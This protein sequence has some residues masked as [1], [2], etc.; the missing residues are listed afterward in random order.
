MAYAKRYKRKTPVRRYKRN[1]ASVKK[2]ASICRKVV[3]KNIETKHSVF[4]TSDGTEIAHNN[5]ITVTNTLLRTTQG[6]GDN[7]VANVSNR[8]GDS[9]TIKGVAIRMMLELNERYSDIVCRVLII[10][11][12]KNDTPTRASLFYGQSGNKMLDKI[13]NERYTVIAQKF[14]KIK[15]AN[16]ATQGASIATIAGGSA[17]T[18]LAGGAYTTQS[19]ATSIQKMWIPGYKFKKGMMTYETGSDQP[20]F[21]DYH[22]LVYAY[23]NY[24]TNQDVWNIARLNDCIIEM[25]YKDA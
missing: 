7:P 3:A 2:I 18:N 11:S 17:G 22:C 24:S 9:I 10:R 19:R 23:S 4:S 25:Y 1:S 15:A 16:T 20:K 12:A 21:F 14:C 5:F 6:T 13:N 8:I